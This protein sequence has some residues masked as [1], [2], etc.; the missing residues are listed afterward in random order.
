VIRIIHKHG[1]CFP[2]TGPTIQ[3]QKKVGE[4]AQPIQPRQSGENKQRFERDRY[5][6]QLLNFACQAGIEQQAAS[7][8]A[9]LILDFR[10]VMD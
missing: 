7:H 10:D 6:R 4:T 8:P 5:H 1:K 9:T 3:D 2:H